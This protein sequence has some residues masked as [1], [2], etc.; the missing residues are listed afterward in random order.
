MTYATHT[1][2]RER[3]PQTP[4]SASHHRATLRVMG[5]LLVFLA[6]VMAGRIWWGDGTRPQEYFQARSGNLKR[7]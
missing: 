5:K 1:L 7:S 4:S 6:G 2:T 3:T